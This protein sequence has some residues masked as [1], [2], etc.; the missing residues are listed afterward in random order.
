MLLNST[1]IPNNVIKLICSGELT[2]VETKI[3]LAICRQTIGWNKETD[4]MTFKRFMQ[5]TNLKRP[6][7]STAINSLIARKIIERE[8]DAGNY[9][10]SLNVTFFEDSQLF[11][12]KE[13]PVLKKGTELFLKKEPIKDTRIKETNTESGNAPATPDEKSKKTYS[14]TWYKNQD[15]INA[16]KKEWQ[17][18]EYNSPNDK[19]IFDYHYL[20]NHGKTTPG[21]LFG[22]LYWKYKQS[23]SNDI[24]TYQFR[25]GE[26]AWGCFSAEQKAAEKL[27]NMLT[28]QESVS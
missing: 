1:Q 18:E 23:L 21:K 19:G 16:H 17:G 15:F 13:Q 24:F 12:K 6:A 5:L 11:S 25:T 3:V 7:L 28:V 9:Y 22:A 10:Y 14:L 8:G 27:A 26:Q 20:L 4:W 2:H